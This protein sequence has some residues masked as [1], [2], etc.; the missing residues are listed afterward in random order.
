VRTLKR[1]DIIKRNLGMCDCKR[2]LRKASIVIKITAINEERHI[3][4]KHLK[5]LNELK[6]FNLKESIKN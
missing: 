5:K 3:C 6:L 4:T 1:I 2:C